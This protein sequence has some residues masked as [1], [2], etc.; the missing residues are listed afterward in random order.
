V[1]RNN[2]GNQ[3]EGEAEAKLGGLQERE[4]R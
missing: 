1:V 4:W 3:R 2:V